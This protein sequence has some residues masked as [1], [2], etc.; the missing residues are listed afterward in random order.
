M[1]FFIKRINFNFKKI[2]IF[3]NNKIM[4]LKIVPFLSLVLV[5]LSLNSTI[6][7]QSICAYERNIDYFIS[8]DI[9]YVFT[10]APE[11]C[12]SLC[13]IQ[14]GCIGLLIQHD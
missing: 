1:K 10:R 3:N 9:T 8:T 6:A 12:C 4:S 14:P 13:G 11:F 5:L 2:K 7:Q